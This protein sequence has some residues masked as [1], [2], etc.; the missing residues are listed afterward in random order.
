MM[1]MTTSSS[2]RVNAA[3]NDFFLIMVGMVVELCC[4]IGRSDEK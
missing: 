3:V 1:V 4:G 2:I